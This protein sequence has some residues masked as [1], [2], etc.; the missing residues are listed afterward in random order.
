MQLQGEEITGTFSSRILGE[1]QITGTVKG[2]AIQF[3]FEGE[4]GGQAVTVTYK[5]TIVGPTAMK[6]TAIYSGLDVKATWSATKK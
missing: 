2:A 3:Q 6:G 5:G 1:T 4:A